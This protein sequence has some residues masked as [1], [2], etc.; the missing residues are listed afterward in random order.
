MKLINQNELEIELNDLMAEILELR[1]AFE[2]CMID[3]NR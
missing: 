1:K 3:A 2:D